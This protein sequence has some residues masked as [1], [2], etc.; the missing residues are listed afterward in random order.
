MNVEYINP[1]I[2]GVETLF[3]TMLD[4][5]AERGELALTEEVA[6]ARDVTA[7]IGLSG[8]ASGIVALSFPVATAL[9]MTGHLLGQEIRVM[10][11]DVT[12]AMAEMVNIVAGAAK[13]KL[14][15][16]TT[17][18]DLGLPTVV[19]GSD[20]RVEQP[21]GTQWLDVPFTTKFGPLAMRVAFELKE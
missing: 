5:D 16:G 18:I 20:V 8:P 6:T 17:P 1:F 19:R 3:K 12:D 11:A 14:S 21:R 2:E 15:N 4:S 9:A 13:A 7:I 10:N